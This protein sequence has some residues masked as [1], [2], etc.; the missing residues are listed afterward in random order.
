M[1]RNGG[2]ARAIARIKSELIAK[3][4]RGQ[5]PD[6]N[7]RPGEGRQIDRTL[8]DS[9]GGISDASPTTVDSGMVVNHIQG[10]RGHASGRALPYG[11]DKN[12]LN[13]AGRQI[14]S[15]DKGD[16]LTTGADRWFV[17]ERANPGIGDLRI[18]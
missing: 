4:Q 2:N 16:R 3:C 11:R 14:A 10:R 13:P 9:G 1:V 7:V 15:S 12:F 18:G 6:V 5:R 17:I 8:A